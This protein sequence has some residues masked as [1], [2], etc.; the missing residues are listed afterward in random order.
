MKAIERRR[1][2][3]FELISLKIKLKIHNKMYY[4]LKNLDVGRI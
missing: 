4:N 1:L 3:N 2:Y